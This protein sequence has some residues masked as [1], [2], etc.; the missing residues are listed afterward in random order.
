MLKPILFDLGKL[1]LEI[2]CEWVGGS[3]PVSREMLSRILDELRS[4]G[5]LTID[6]LI[7]KVRGSNAPQKQDIAHLLDTKLRPLLASKG[8]KS[9]HEELVKNKSNIVEQSKLIVIDYAYLLMEPFG[10]K[11]K[12][13]MQPKLSPNFSMAWHGIAHMIKK[14]IW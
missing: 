11:R 5:E 13:S 10:M 6:A 12:N 1:P 14:E 4:K 9:L 7:N 8:Q 3:T 2:V